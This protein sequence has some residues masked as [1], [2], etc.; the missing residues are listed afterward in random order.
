MYDAW[1][2]QNN[3]IEKIK[4]LDPYRFG[5]SATAEEL[6]GRARYIE[7]LCKLVANHIE[8]LLADASVSVS[9]AKIDEE[10]ARAIIDMGADLA[11][12]LTE[13]AW[14]TMEAA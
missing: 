5:L 4:K 2:D 14:Q 1:Q 8:S 10:D 3:L 7:E 6:E 11:A 12:Q 13:A 9:V